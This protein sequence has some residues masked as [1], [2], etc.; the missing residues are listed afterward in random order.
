M[1]LALEA[2]RDLKRVDA[3]QKTSAPRRRSTGYLLIAA[4]AVGLVV[5]NGQRREPMGP[6]HGTA[7]TQAT[8]ATA[9]D[10][11]PLRVGTFNIH[12]GKGDDRVRDLARVADC[13][14]GLHVVGLNEVHGATLWGSEDQAAALG[15]MLGMPWLYAPTEQRWWHEQFGNGA[16]CQLP[17]EHWQRIPLALEH[18][19]SYRNALLLQTTY[20]DRPLRVIVTHIDRRDDRDRRAQLRAVGELFLSLAEPVI[21]MGDMNTGADDPLIQRLVDAP[22][23]VDPV[24]EVMGAETPKRIDWILARG[25]RVR[26]AALVQTIASDHPYVWA[27]LELAD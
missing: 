10:D 12:G 13:L 18:G 22:G 4:A 1:S 27:E 20:R 5:W 21:L 25:F 23:V 19:K 24:G 15:R 2:S 6:A 8:A 11:A 14:R 7:F 16:L 26:D 17:V 9:L 3:P